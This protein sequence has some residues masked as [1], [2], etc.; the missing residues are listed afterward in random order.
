MGIL[1]GED[2][3]RPGGTNRG[4]TESF[5]L[6]LSLPVHTSHIGNSEVRRR[7]VHQAHKVVTMVAADNEAHTPRFSI[8]ICLQ[9]GK[10]CTSLPALAFRLPLYGTACHAHQRQE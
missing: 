8:G 4:S 7:L 3:G 5:F 1:A 9:P 2:T 10:L 6:M